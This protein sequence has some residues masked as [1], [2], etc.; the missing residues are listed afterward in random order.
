MPRLRAATTEDLT[1]IVSWIQTEEDCQLWSGGRL[2]FP[3][4]IAS[5]PENIGF[6]AAPCW[7]LIEGQTLLGFGQIVPKDQGRMHFAR[8]IV[9]PKHRGHG[10]GNLLT[11]R[12]LKRALDLQPS[13]ISLNVET[14]NRPAIAIYQ[15]LGFVPSPLPSDEPASQSLFMQRSVSISNE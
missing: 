7:S 4:D 5:L 8:L 11:A 15:K 14:S 9:N 3:I 6:P 13:S 2:S 10:L 12:L 1:Q